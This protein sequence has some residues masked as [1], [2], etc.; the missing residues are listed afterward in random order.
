MT[1]RA[2]NTADI[3]EDVDA[4]LA[5]KLDIVNQQSNRNLLYN[6]AMQVHQRGTSATGITGSSYNT[7][8]RWELAL[9]TMGTWTNTVENDAPTGSGFRKSWKLLCTTSDSTPAAGDLIFMRQKLEGQD[10]QR[11]A[12]G[13]SAAQQLTVSF[14][15]K[16]NVTGTYVAELRD[17]DNNRSVSAQYAISASGTWEKKTIT[18]PADTT[19][20]LDND[21]ALSLACQFWLGAGTDSTSGTLQTTWAAV[22]NANRAVGQ[23][24]LAAATNNYWQITGVQLEVGPNATEF[25]FKSFGQELLECQRYFYLHASGNNKAVGNGSMLTSSAMYSAIN[26][27]TSMRSG[28]SLVVATG[29]NFYE[30]FRNA[31]QDLFDSFIIDRPTENSALIYNDSQISGTAGHAGSVFTNNSGGSVAFTAEL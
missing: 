5:T 23:T 12:K 18:F 7:A 3:V 13:T 19:G 8:D 30:F 17:F 31:A 26:F 24:N 28:P 2:R 21:N 25:E 14:W 29:T 10:V 6:G 15:V 9:G 11:I 22:V 16:S 27:P 20:V 1:T 4:S